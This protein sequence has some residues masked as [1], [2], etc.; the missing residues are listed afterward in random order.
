MPKSSTAS[1]NLAQLWSVQPMKP[2]LTVNLSLFCRRRFCWKT[3]SR[4]RRNNN[5]NLTYVQ[6][7]QT[8]IHLARPDGR[9]SDRNRCDQSGGRRARD[10]RLEGEGGQGALRQRSTRRSNSPPE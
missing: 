10:P 9:E 4:R 8:G 6:S 3:K 7:N 2:S 5:R 1:R